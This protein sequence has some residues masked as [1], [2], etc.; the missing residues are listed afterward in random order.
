MITPAN[1]TAGPARG[2]C[3]AAMIERLASGR[4]HLDGKVRHEA[5]R[6]L[7]NIVGV[8][9]GTDEIGTCDVVASAGVPGAVPSPG[10]TERLDRYWAARLTG[11]CAHVDDFDDTHL[12]TVIH[13]SA[14]LIGAL[15]GLGLDS[16][17]AGTLLSAIAVGTEVQLRIG[18][19]MTPWHYDRGWHITGTCGVIGAAV[20]AGIAA[21]RTPADVVRAAGLAARMYVGNRESFGSMVKSLNAG[22]AAANGLLAHDLAGD[23]QSGGAGDFEA[24]GGYF[25]LL[26]GTWDD[27]WLRPDDIGRRWLALDN[28]YKPYPCGVVAHPAIEAAVGLEPLLSLRQHPER[29]A[30]IEAI[31]VTCHPLVPDLMGKPRPRNGLE[32]RFSAVHGVAVG[33]IDGKAGLLQFSDDRVRSPEV[34]AVRNL[35]ALRPQAD[36]GRAA[37]TV[38]LLLKDG[39]YF[40][41]H[42]RSVVSSIE[43]PLTDDQLSAKFTD[44]VAPVFGA[45]SAAQLL[46]I[47]WS[48]GAGSEPADLTRA[49]ADLPERTRRAR[50]AVP[51]PN[52]GAQTASAELAAFVVG[53]AAGRIPD[54]ALARAR[55]AI[56]L[57][58]TATGLPDADVAP[59]EAPEYRA[60]A[61]ARQAAGHPAD[62]ENCLELPVI[63]A[64]LALNVDDETAATAVTIGLEVCARIKAALNL[65]RHP[66]WLAAGSLAQVGAAMAAA[67]ASGLDQAKALA[68]LGIA[69]TMTSGLAAEPEPGTAWL[70]Q[71]KAASDGVLAVRL[72]AAGMDGPAAPVEGPRGMAA[73]LSA[74]YCDSTVLVGDLGNSWLLPTAKPAAETPPPRQ[75]A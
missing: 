52:E 64:V 68:A 66:Q 22:A 17:D 14:P 21:Q 65:G 18:M 63:A 16:T 33:L 57:T 30:Q 55:Q 73:L 13:P 49:L 8:I 31:E 35:V 1:R 61:L 32:G 37:A 67:R 45:R 26:A 3:V 74:G 19:A 44:L 56:A 27:Q 10:R 75:P 41:S 46:G 12:A 4:E 39:R 29:A 2:A 69:A 9:L 42:V 23:A 47:L 5:R 48:M 59:D 51:R 62:P 20:A 53:T 15:V 34:D 7:L 43:R 36:C 25:A 54:S 6:A 28:S 38:R 71:A 70:Q 58:R 11:V 72:A 60:F 24:E 50:A 40:D